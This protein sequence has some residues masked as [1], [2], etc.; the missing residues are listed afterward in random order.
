MRKKILLTLILFTLTTTMSSQVTIGSGKKPNAGSL[1][2]LKEKETV[3]GG[4]NA[5]RGV[6]MPRV[7]LVDKYKLQPM[8]NYSSQKPTGED[9]KTHIGLVVYNTHQGDIQKG[10]SLCPG[11]YVWRGEEWIPL[12]NTPNKPDITIYDTD[13]NFYRAKWYSYDPCDPNGGNYWLT[14][15]LRTT[16]DRNGKAFKGGIKLNP[17]KFDRI[18][19]LAL[20]INTKADLPVTTDTKYVSYYE[21]N[22]KITESYDTYV[23]KFGLMYTYEQAKTACPPGWHTATD[24][25][26]EKLFRALGAGTASDKGKKLMANDWAYKALSIN[27]GVSPAVDPNVFTNGGGYPASDARNSGFGAYPMGAAHTDNSIG[28]FGANCYW[29]ADTNKVWYLI[30]S[31]GQFA[32]DARDYSIFCFPVRC[33]RDK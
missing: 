1:L 16:R 15:N 7:E 28:E 12:Y 30:W 6:N 11:L 8:F 17:A 13:N 20:T 19:K 4:A 10:D 5:E 21:N 24:N 9:L 18:K 31:T 2:D 29:W 14:S 3:N 33:V 27:D 22:L 25:D 23:S 26:W 32:V